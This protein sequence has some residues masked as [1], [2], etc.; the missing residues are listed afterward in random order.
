MN[1][2][3]WYIFYGDLE[4]VVLII[5]AL[6]SE[7][8]SGGP[9][10]SELGLDNRLFLNACLWSCCTTGS[11]SWE[12]VLTE[13][14]TDLL[15]KPMMEEE[16]PRSLNSQH[17]WLLNFNGWKWTM[18]LFTAWIKGHFL[19]F[20]SIFVCC[21]WKYLAVNIYRIIYPLLWWISYKIDLSLSR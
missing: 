4:T 14:C 2:Q 3:T 13:A 21:M 19:E 12:A 16:G 8:T 9:F 11:Y 10:M 17:T 20:C 7:S 15:H 18:D 5:T 6:H 1:D